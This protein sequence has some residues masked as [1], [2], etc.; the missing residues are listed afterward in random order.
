[1]RR[2]RHSIPLTGIF[3]VLILIAAPAAFGQ[4]QIK[5]NDDTFFRLGLLLQTQAEALQDPASRGYAQNVYVRR[6]RLLLGGQIAKNITFFLETDS[7]NLGKSVA[8]GTKNSQPSLYLQDA[9]VEFKFNDAFAL[10]AG[11]MLPSPS[12]NGLQ[13]AA[14]LLPLDYGPYTFANSGPTQ[15][16]VGRDTGI[17]AKGYLL[18]KKLEY[19]AGLFQ[20]MRD[21]TDR[22]LRFTG[23]LQYNFLEAET[24]FFYT[25]TYLGKKKVLA[26]GTGIDRQHDY[27][28]YAFDVFFDHPV[29]N[30]AITAQA[31]LIRYDGGA[32]LKTLPRQTDLLVEAGYLIGKTRFMPVVQFTNRSFSNGGGF[33][34]TR[35][36]AGLNYFLTGHNAN[37][38]ALYT[39]IDN[40]GTRAANQ[41]TVQIQFFYY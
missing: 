13:S 16:N 14:S 26:V 3:L 27:T 8:A 33:D 35:T 15:S 21:Q 38:K 30:G 5:V 39:R 37:I 28:G 19:R 6:V 31:D 4:V 20:G 32:F 9:Y 25:G 11:L 18:N 17:Q 40:D 23:R 36:S 22:E 24:G 7:P 12:R 34:E 2:R 29:G 10:D 1:M 41:A